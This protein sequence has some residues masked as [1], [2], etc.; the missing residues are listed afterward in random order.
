ML[1]TLSEICQ[2]PHELKCFSLNFLQ[3]RNSRSALLSLIYGKSVGGGQVEETSDSVQ[4]VN[5]HIRTQRHDVHRYTRYEY[6]KTKS[7]YIRACIDNAKG[8]LRRFCDIYEE[9]AWTR[10]FS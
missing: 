8:I 4:Y 1:P 7:I 9:R 5:I 10:E 2:K 3:C 6:T